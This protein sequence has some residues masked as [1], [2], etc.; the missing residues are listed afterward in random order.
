MQHQKRVQHVG[1]PRKDLFDISSA[2]ELLVALLL[3]GGFFTVLS[4]EPALLAVAIPL[5]RMLP[6]TPREKQRF[7]N[8]FGYLKRKGYIEVTKHR[9]HV[10]VRITERGTQRGRV[11]YFATDI[12]IP[13]KPTEWDREWRLIIFDIP[14]VDRIKRDALRHMLKRLGAVMLQQ[15]VW[16]H[17]YDCSEQVAFLK[18]YFDV[19]DKNIRLIVARDVGD[20]RWLR[21][22][23][24]L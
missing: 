24:K 2:K 16:A 20:D 5:A 4:I 22:Q 15:S 8:A 14:S 21:R 9:R 13:R 12:S 6:N 10:S 19:R 11:A 23:F 1:E 7:Q 18:K 17:P 3:V